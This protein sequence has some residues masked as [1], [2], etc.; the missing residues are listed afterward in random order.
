MIITERL[1]GNRHGR[2]AALVGLV[3]SGFLLLP[4][5]CIIPPEDKTPMPVMW[6]TMEPASRSENLVVFIPGRRDKPQDF[7]DKGFVDALWSAG[8]EADVALPDAHLGYYYRRTFSERFLADVIELARDRG[9]REIWAVGVSLGG[10]G[11][12]MF[13]RDHPGTWNGVVLVAPFAGDHEAVLRQIREAPNLQAVH[14]SQNT[15]DDDYTENFWNWLQDYQRHPSFPIFLGYGEQ[16]RMQVEQ[17]LIAEIL[18]QDSVVAIPGKHEWSTWKQLWD[19]MLPLIPL[20]GR[21]R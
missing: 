5:G 14:F 10:F 8:V 16:D 4:G 1:T 11:A 20:Q 9:Y 3:L 19:K 12:L 21:D 15:T 13:E 18:P 2:R 6:K 7:L 17:A